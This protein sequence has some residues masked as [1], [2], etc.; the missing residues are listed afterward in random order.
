MPFNI[1]QQIDII[2]RGLDFNFSCYNDNPKY[3]TYKTNLT[4]VN[5]LEE[6]KEKE[7]EEIKY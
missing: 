6:G 3:A 7:E 5:I 2:A 1:A 4:I